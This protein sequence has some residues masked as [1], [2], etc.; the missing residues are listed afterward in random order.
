M[1]KLV[2]HCYICHD[3]RPMLDRLEHRRGGPMPPPECCG[4][5]MSVAEAKQVQERA[6]SV[7]RC[8]RCRTERLTLEPKMDCLLGPPECCGADM[9]QGAARVRVHPDRTVELVDGP[10]AGQRLVP[11]EGIVHA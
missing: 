10:N 1:D 7:W 8:K 3:E 5:Q 11:G 6:W 2:W 4:Y 9:Q